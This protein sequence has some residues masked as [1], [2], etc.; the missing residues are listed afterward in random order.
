MQCASSLVRTDRIITAEF[1]RLGGSRDPLIRNERS[2]I[3]MTKS[4][5]QLRA[6][7]SRGLH[8]N[9]EAEGDW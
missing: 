1:A 5:A 8:I 7:I 2:V 3:T 9:V 4:I 6:H